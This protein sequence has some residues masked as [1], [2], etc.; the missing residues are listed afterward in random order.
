MNIPFTTRRR[1]LWGDCDP[2]G[3][4]YT[5]RVF[6]YAIETV[7]EWMLAVLGHDWISFQNNLGLGTPT[8]QMGCRFMHPI[9]CGDWIE[10]KLSIKKLGGASI[11]YGIDGYNEDQQHCFEVDQISCFVDAEKI[12]PVRIA[13]EFRDK[14]AAYAAACEEKGK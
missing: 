10:L 1:I 7:E 2:A 3:I 4:V 6:H 11:N 13:E 14:I 9:R 12:E 8:V 5:P